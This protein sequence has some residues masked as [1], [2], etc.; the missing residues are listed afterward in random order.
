MLTKT[1][2]YI[3]TNSHSKCFIVRQPRGKR[4]KKVA[5]L[6]SSS[7][8]SSRPP[9]MTKTALSG[10]GA[11]SVYT[12]LVAVAR[13]WESPLLFL[14]CLIPVSLSS[15]A[16]PPSFLPPSTPPA[17]TAA[18]AADGWLGKPHD[19]NEVFKVGSSASSSKRGR[20]GTHLFCIE[21]QANTAAAAAASAW[22]EATCVHCGSE[23]IA[24]QLP[25]AI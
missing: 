2:G 8:S 6:G 25:W 19:L 4:T 5:R 20:R 1:L 12:R 10:R 21:Q 16:G 14:T 17:A 11:A 22:F 7:R 13:D 18:A 15:Q 3:R 9:G 24:H 23:T